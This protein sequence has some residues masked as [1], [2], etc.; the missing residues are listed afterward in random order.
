[1]Q[2]DDE[3][4]KK[5]QEEKRKSSVFWAIV[6]LGFFGIVFF[7]QVLE[8]L[9][10]VTKVGFEQAKKTSPPGYGIIVLLLMVSLVF[11]FFIY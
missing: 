3:N 1:M 11:G 4:E 7:F 2:I 9:D 10:L 5:Q 8:F 6:I